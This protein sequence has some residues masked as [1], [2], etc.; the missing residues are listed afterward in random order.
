MD[1][2]N[3]LRALSDD[4]LLHRLGELV[5]NS[6]RIE[7]DLVAHIAE[8]DERRLYAREAC[9]SMFVYCTERL[10]LSEPEAYLRITVARAA[11]KHPILLAMLRDGRLHLSG[12]ALLAPLLTEE[13]RDAVLERARNCSKRR[14]EELVAELS[15]RPDAASLMR[16]LPQ[17]AASA[18]ELRPDAVGV[19]VATSGEE[20]AVPGSG[21]SRAGVFE[22][23]HGGISAVAELRPDGVAARSAMRPT[24][25]AA[26]E[27]LSPSRY[28][29]QFTASAELRG[30]L[31][32]LQALM[33]AEIPDGDLGSIIDRAVSEK[34][35]RLEARRF[36]KTV[37]P[38]KEVAGSNSLP[39]TRYIPAAVRR[40]VRERD[41]ERCHYVDAQGRRCAER[42]RLEFHHVHP[43]GMGGDHSPG[44]IRLVCPSHNRYLAE[45]DYGQSAVLERRRSGK[46]HEASRHAPNSTATALATEHG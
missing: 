27:T 26:V 17:R 43:F 39:V 16:K 37:A 33:R 20:T 42:D 4:E 10:H 7:A 44:N 6:R 28:K 5:T 31:E 13:N 29:V 9:P 35:E 23:G 18:I 19:A 40:T 22:L 46:G 36:A 45:R 41:G 25:Q 15:P 3:L 12:V 30:K 32:R 2:T 24:R 11:R 34:L 21:P 1:S 8:V 14:I 38:R